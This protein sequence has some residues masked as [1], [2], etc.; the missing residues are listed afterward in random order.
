MSQVKIIYRDDLLEGELLNRFGADFE[1]MVKQTLSRFGIW[2]ILVVFRLYTHKRSKGQGTLFRYG[3]TYPDTPEI[4]L[5][6]MHSREE[7]ILT[8]LHEIVHL[9]ECPTCGNGRLTEKQVEAKAQQLYYRGIY[10]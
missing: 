10:G 5:S 1:H 4:W 6:P 7:I 2:H 8:F 9:L 3:L